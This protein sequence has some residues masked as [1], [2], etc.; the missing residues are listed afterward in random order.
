MKQLEDEENAKRYKYLIDFEVDS[1]KTHIQ[2]LRSKINFGLP[3]NINGE[4]YKNEHDRI[5]EQ[6]NLIYEF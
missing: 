2:F 5:D 4:K 6:E 1:N 3:L